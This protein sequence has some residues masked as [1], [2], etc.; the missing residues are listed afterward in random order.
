MYI[1]I[2]TYIPANIDE[3]VYTRNSG[4]MFGLVSFLLYISETFH[5]FQRLV[6]QLL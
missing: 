5:E 3:Y 1:N 2:N 6:P 4:L